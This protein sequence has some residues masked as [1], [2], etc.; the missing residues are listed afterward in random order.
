MLLSLVLAALVPALPAAADPLPPA[1]D[2][3]IT[4]DRRPPHK[5]GPDNNTPSWANN[6]LT[7]YCGQTDGGYV[8]AAQAFL[9]AAGHYAGAVDNYWGSKS[10]SAM[11][12]YQTERQTLQRD[13]CAGPETW[14]DIQ[15]RARYVGTTTNCAGPGSLD[16]Y[17]YSRLGRDAIY[18]RSTVTS[19]WYTDTW[20]VPRGGPVGEHL[21]RFS[22]NLVVRC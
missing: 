20:Y 8:I 17:R 15:A 12:S 19:Y 7:G 11:L 4:A 10:H 18:D 16:V 6:S 9:Y 2:V 14:A 13:G 5:S 21:Y 22:D 1:P 3:T